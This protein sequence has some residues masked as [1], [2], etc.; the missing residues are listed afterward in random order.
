MRSPLPLTLLVVLAAALLSTAGAMAAPPQPTNVVPVTFHTSPAGAKVFILRSGRDKV[1]GR[2]DEG[3]LHAIGLSGQPILMDPAMFDD[4]GGGSVRLNLRFKLDEHASEDV[5]IDRDVL[6]SGRWPARG[7]FRLE[8]TTFNARV[9]DLFASW[10]LLIGLGL[11]GGIGAGVALWLR[12]R[13]RRA[14]TDRAAQLEVYQ[15]TSPD[16]SW[17]G[18]KLGRYRLVSR[19]GRGGMATVYRA[20]P[21]DTLDERDA[22]AVKVVNVGDDGLDDTFRARFRREVRVSTM[23]SHPNI[24]RVID[25]GA[26]EPLFIVMELLKGKTLGDLRRRHGGKMAPAACVDVVRP[27]FEAIQYAHDKGVVHRDLKPDNIMLTENGTLKVM[28]FGIARTHNMSMALTADGNTL[29]TPDYMAP[30]QVQG[31]AETAS[32]Q[33]ALGVI[34]YELLCGRRPHESG[35]LMS[36]LLARVTKNAIPLTEFDPRLG[37]VEMALMRMLEI[38]PADRYPSVREAFDA[39][40]RAVG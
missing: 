7:S 5:I 8:P 37:R 34:T 29:G 9:R 32:D 30:E 16:D 15:A 38:N 14:A 4:P 31:F 26:D 40:E 39:L 19:L 3:Y 36:M 22:V 11:M 20:V 35:E 1:E 13:A 24:V 21:D 6:S 10:G 27:L 18:A 28:D 25:W 23:M 2:E 17:I 12:E 33:Y